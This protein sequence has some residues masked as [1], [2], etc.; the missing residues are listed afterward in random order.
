MSP[1]RPDAPPR[2]MLKAESERLQSYAEFRKSKEKLQRALAKSLRSSK[3]IEE[4]AAG[5]MNRHEQAVKDLESV[6]SE[7]DDFLREIT[8]LHREY[9][10]K[11]CDTCDGKGTTTDTVLANYPCWDRLAPAEETVTVTCETCLGTCKDWGV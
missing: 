2:T 4:S 10:E 3:L 7:R 1:P 8:D 11:D 6:T 9:V 5:W